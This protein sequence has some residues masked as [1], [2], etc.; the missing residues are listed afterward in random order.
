MTDIGGGR[1]RRETAAQDGAAALS[2]ISECLRYL[3]C[4]YGL[5]PR[6]RSACLSILEAGLRSLDVADLQAAVKILESS[7]RLTARQRD[8]ASELSLRLRAVAES[9]TK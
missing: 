2:D 1:G 9:P 6:E 8:Q 5:D 7:R 4:G 3:A